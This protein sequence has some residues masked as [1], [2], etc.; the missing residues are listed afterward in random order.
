MRL[1]LGVGKSW[2]IS[3][4]ALVSLGLGLFWAFNHASAAGSIVCDTVEAGVE[5]TCTAQSDDGLS[6]IDSVMSQ[7]VNVEYYSTSLGLNSATVTTT[8]AIPPDGDT[9]DYVAST[10]STFNFFWT[11]I[12]AQ[13][14]ETPP[15]NAEDVT[16]NLRICNGYD[17]VNSDTV[18]LCTY[19]TGEGYCVASTDPGAPGTGEWAISDPMTE[20]DKAALFVY[21]SSWAVFGAAALWTFK[22][23]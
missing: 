7:D 20:T 21:V 13:F 1:Y 16:V 18:V 11:D 15:D 6:Y 23:K 14:S 12:L 17:C 22:K 5:W 9:S 10:P 19:D 3:W 4:S 2:R 8:P